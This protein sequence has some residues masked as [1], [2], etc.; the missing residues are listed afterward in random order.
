MTRQEKIRKV[1]KNVKST[2]QIF[3]TYG[4]V[5]KIKH[6]I[7]IAVIDRFIPTLSIP[8][9]LAKRYLKGHFVITIHNR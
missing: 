8:T 5:L 9:I 3:N 4:K 2:K 6:W 1:L 7:V